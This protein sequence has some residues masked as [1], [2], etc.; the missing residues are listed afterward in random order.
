M[1]NLFIK[2]YLKIIKISSFNFIEKNFI[3]RFDYALKNRDEIFLTDCSSF[4][5][6]LLSVG[7]KVIFLL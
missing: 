7:C 6:E 3:D 1:K 2:K 4:G 5:K